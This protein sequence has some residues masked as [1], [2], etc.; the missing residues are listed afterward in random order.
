MNQSNQIY[1]QTFSVNKE[2]RASQKNQRGSCL[3]L[4]GLSGAGKTT[5]ANSLDKHLYQ[6]KHKYNR[7]YK[8]KI[9]AKTPVSRNLVPMILI[10]M[11][12]ALSARN[13]PSVILLFRPCAASAVFPDTSFS[14]GCCVQQQTWP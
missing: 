4:T 1:W 12:S 11:S 9:N 8:Q 6:L 10:L 3:W 7:T 13:E 5:I 14:V 2:D